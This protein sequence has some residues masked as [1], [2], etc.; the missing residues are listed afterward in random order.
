MDGIVLFVL[1]PVAYIYVL[2]KM[3]LSIA[4]H[5]MTSTGFVLVVLASFIFFKERF[6]LLQIIGLALIISGLW[7]VT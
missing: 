1:A 7:I 4:H 5:I 3:N 2:S 6:T